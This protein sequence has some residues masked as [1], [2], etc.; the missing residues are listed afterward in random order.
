MNQGSGP[1]FGPAFTATGILLE[2]A[3]E[4]DARRGVNAVPVQPCSRPAK[5]VMGTRRRL[6]VA[7]G[8]AARA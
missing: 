2:R 3:L 5:G 8:W 7:S 4:A 6:G 1:R